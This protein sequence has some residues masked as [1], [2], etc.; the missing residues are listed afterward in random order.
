M[1]VTLTITELAAELRIGDGETAPVEP[2]AGILTRHLQAARREIMAHAPTAP[3]PAMTIAA[4]RLIGYRYFQPPASAGMSF[5]HAL[6][7]SGAADALREWRIPPSAVIDYTGSEVE[8]APVPEPEPVELPPVFYVGSLGSA[9]THAARLERLRGGGFDEA[10]LARIHGPI[11][12]DI[13]A[14]SPAEIAVAIMAEITQTLRRPG[15]TP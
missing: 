6:V 12:L 13:G 9:K 5:A 1:S 2:I 14:K 11:G 7:N 10:A 3:D 15:S 4:I 8:P